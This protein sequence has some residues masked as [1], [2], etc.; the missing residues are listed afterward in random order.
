MKNSVRTETRKKRK[1]VLVLFLCHFHL[2]IY[3]L[4]VIRHNH[5]YTLY[6]YIYIFLSNIHLLLTPNKEHHDVFCNIPVIG[7]KRGKSL[8]DI[9]VRAKLPKID[10]GNGKCVKC[11]KKR[12][13]VCSSLKETQTFS[14]KEGR[15]FSIKNGTMNCDSKHV[16]YLLSCKQCKIQYVGS[17]STPFRL[18]YNNY[19]CCFR[20]FSA[21]CPAVPQESLH[22]HFAQDDHHGRDDWEFVLIDQAEDIP[23][24]RRR[25][26]FWQN[27]LNTFIPYGLN[28]REVAVD[29]G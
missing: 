19:K 25:E 4:V 18:R 9:L 11:G 8:K 16:V 21:G 10:Q 27:Y 22:A 6:I 7:F 23:S 1:G 15:E 29:F 14:N 3:Y 26:T 20:K 28:E 5:L 17:T 2:Y 12:C 13:G 24:A